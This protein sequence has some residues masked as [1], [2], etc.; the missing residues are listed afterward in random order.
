MGYSAGFT[1]EKWSENDIFIV[2]ELMIDGKTKKEIIDK[3]T[4]KICSS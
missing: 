4:E 2:L 1:K 3:V